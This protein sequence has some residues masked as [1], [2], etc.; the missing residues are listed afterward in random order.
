MVCGVLLAAFLFFLEYVS[1]AALQTIQSGNGLMI[2]TAVAT[3]LWAVITAVIFT[4]RASGWMVPKGIGALLAWIFVPA[5][6]F[7]LMYLFREKGT[8]YMLSVLAIVWVADIVAYFGGRCLGGPKNGRR[9]QSEKDLV[10]RADGFCKCP[11]FV[12]RS[13]L[14]SAVLPALD[15]RSDLSFNRLGFCLDPDRSSSVFDCRRL[16]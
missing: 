1:P 13:L 6:W 12:V 15:Q 10:R 3:V 8:I 7:S 9:H 5:A 16:V 2:I 11:G 4:R 14:G